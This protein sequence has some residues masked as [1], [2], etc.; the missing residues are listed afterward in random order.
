MATPNNSRPYQPANNQPRRLRRANAIN[1]FCQPLAK[2]KIALVPVDFIGAGVL[3]QSG[4]VGLDC[5]DCHPRPD[6]WRNI[7]RQAWRELVGDRW[8]NLGPHT[9]VCYAVRLAKS[10]LPYRIPST[11]A[12]ECYPVK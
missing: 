3:F 9:E 11:Y 12:A 8:T 6:E 7:G 2:G 1:L 10:D 5:L 4:H